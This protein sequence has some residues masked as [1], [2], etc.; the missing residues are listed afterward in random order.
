[1]KRTQQIAIWGS[2]GGMILAAI[3]AGCG[4]GSTSA[5]GPPGGGGG[6]PSPTPAPSV[7]PVLTG[8]LNVALSGSYPTQVE[9]AAANAEV[10]F[11]CG[12]TGVAGT[13]TADGTGNFNIVT[14]STPVPTPN[15]RRRRHRDGM[16][17][18]PVRD[19]IARPSIAIS[20][21]RGCCWP[22]RPACPAVL[23]ART[24]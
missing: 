9:G 7:T 3:I 18:Q 11:T 8:N 4:G 19:A 1:M 17:R 12:C 20:R 6:H 21:R 13:G 24:S 2:L 10:D 15:P 16:T 22:T 23:I 5:V 14:D